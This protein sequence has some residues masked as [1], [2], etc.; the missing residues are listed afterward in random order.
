MQALR[1]QPTTS[2]TEGRVTDRHEQSRQ[3][4]LETAI[5]EVEQGFS[6]WDVFAD[7]EEPTD[8][9]E[10]AAPDPCAVSKT[11]SDMTGKKEKRG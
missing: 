6:D 5:E 10:N 9:F 2:R 8:F 11:L 7:D 1:T 4:D 3:L